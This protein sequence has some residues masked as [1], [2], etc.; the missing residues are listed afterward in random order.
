M[1]WRQ[2]RARVGITE[3]PSRAIRPAWGGR[4]PRPGPGRGDTGR[5]TTSTTRSTNRRASS[6]SASSGTPRAGEDP[7]SD[8]PPGRWIFR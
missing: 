5:A 4:G 8:T 2:L 7:H 6:P 3:S 1:A